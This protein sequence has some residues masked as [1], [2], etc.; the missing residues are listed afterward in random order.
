M[1]YNMQHFWETFRANEETPESLRIKRQII[2][3]ATIPANIGTIILSVM[4]VFTSTV[5]VLLSTIFLSIGLLIINIMVLK[6]APIKYV[7]LSFCIVVCPVFSYYVI[8]GGENGFGINWILLIPLSIFM[9]FGLKVGLIISV[10]FLALIC[11]CFYGPAKTLL[12][13]EYSDAVIQRFPIL[14]FLS[15]TFSFIV[16]FQIKSLRI[17]QLKHNKEL[18]LIANK[19]EDERNHY[20]DKSTIDELTQLKNRR[21]FMDTFKRYLS[22]YRQSDNFLCIAIMDIDFF[23]KYNDHYGHL[24]GDECLQ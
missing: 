20:F 16:N 10:Y 9:L 23:K 13:Y 15:F 22:N 17:G 12:L 1:N 24:A 19:L 11:I 8:A 14:Y 2:L 18:V 6:N 21:D 3:T 4:N 5:A 7:A